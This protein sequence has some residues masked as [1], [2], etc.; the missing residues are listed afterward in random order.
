MVFAIGLGSSLR[1]RDLS[2]MYTLGEI[3]EDYAVVSGG[4]YMFTRHK[5]GSTMCSRRPRRRLW[6]PV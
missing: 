1:D 5:A 2:G 4:A 3:L 6:A